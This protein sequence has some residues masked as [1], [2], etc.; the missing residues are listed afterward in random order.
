MQHLNKVLFDWNIFNWVQ[1]VSAR[2]RPVRGAEFIRDA[3]VLSAR[4]H[5]RRLLVSWRTRKGGRHAGRVKRAAKEGVGAGVRV[6]GT[7][8]RYRESASGQV[9]E[10]RHIRYTAVLHAQYSSSRHGR[11]VYVCGIR[12][13][14]T[15]HCV[16]LRRVTYM[17]GY[18]QIF[19]FPEAAIHLFSVYVF[20]KWT[21]RKKFLLI[22]QI[23]ALKYGQRKVSLIL[24]KFLDF[25]YLIKGINGCTDA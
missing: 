1:K 3:V 9:R 21:P 12:T 20:F 11:K 14:C 18:L 23:C 2:I 7:A 5:Q 22:K 15:L 19:I 25:F 6:K 24:K 17:Y 4:R 8:R 16:Y 13:Q 10:C